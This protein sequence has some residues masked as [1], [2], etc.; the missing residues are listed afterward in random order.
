MI[1]VRGETRRIP[2]RGGSVAGWRLA[3]GVARRAAFLIAA[4]MVCIG[5]AGA[6]NMI[7]T[8]AKEKEET[9]IEAIRVDFEKGSAKIREVSGAV[10]KYPTT[11]ILSI[12]PKDKEGEG[13]VEGLRKAKTE[14]QSRLDKLQKD[15]DAQQ[16]VLIQQKNALGITQGL[17][18][19]T[20][21]S[22][23][24]QYRKESQGKSKLIE[25]MNKEHQ[26][27]LAE[28][29]NVIAAL[30]TA[31]PGIVSPRLPE[32]RIS[33]ISLTT[34]TLKGVVRVQ[35]EITNKDQ[36]A[37]S[38]LV[39]EVNVRDAQN[40]LVGKTY[41]FVTAAQPGIARPFTADLELELKKG[42]TPEVTVQSARAFD[43]GKR[44]E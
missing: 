37:Y 2:R 6:G 5:T 18:W 20:S 3:P 44:K 8:L 10:P 35:G 12:E 21:N 9:K 36:S 14:L 24:Q 16:K 13:E 32:V 25:T 31:P 4:W 41:T 38:R 11:A 22:L 27:A 19:G 30:K 43:G 39:L 34:T 15:Y 40:T 28:K 42:M 1:Q 7:V 29:D 23:L 33:A 26:T 17:D